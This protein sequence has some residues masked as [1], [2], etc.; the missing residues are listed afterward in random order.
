MVCTSI[1]WDS[2]TLAVVEMFSTHKQK[3][4]VVRPAHRVCKVAGP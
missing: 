4:S 3:A 2:S 1:A